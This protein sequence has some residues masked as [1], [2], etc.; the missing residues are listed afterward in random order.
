MGPELDFPREAHSDDA[1]KIECEKGRYRKLVLVM[2]GDP[3]TQRKAM[4][5]GATGLLTKPIDFTLRGKR[6]TRGWVR[7]VD[8]TKWPCRYL[9]Q[10]DPGE[11]RCRR[12]INPGSLRPFPC[13]D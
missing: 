1:P 9:A 8:L 4:E 6:S 11:G 10:M 13:V 3:E 7:L 12:R 2:D 5:S